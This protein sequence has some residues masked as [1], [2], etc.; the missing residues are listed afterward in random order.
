MEQ[1]KRL[2][3]YLKPYWWIV[4]IATIFSLC[5]SGVTGAMAWYIK[6]LV[7]GLK[8]DTKVMSL[9]PLLYVAFFL[10]KGVFSFIHSFL[11]RIVGAKVVRDVR[12]ALALNRQNIPKQIARLFQPALVINGIIYQIR[13]AQ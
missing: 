5:V 1:Y 2:L 13:V 11:M 8:T 9:Y 7:D 6:P 12:H 3:R 4:V 10:S